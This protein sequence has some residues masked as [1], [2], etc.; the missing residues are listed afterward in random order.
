M[1]VICYVIVF[2]FSISCL[3]NVEEGYIDLY[4]LHFI[5]IG[6]IAKEGLRPEEQMGEK[7]C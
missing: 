3:W 2:N 4:P 7:E 5:V 6:N 1:V